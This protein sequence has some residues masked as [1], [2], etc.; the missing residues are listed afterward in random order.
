[1]PRSDPVEPADAPEPAVWADDVTISFPTVTGTVDALTGVHASFGPGAVHALVGPTGSG[2]S[3]FLRVLA[4]HERPTSGTIVVAGHVIS[5]MGGR[6]RRRVRRRDIG[7]VF[8][9][10]A[11]N[12]FTYL[13]VDEHLRVAA[14]L[15]A[16]FDP[17]EAAALLDALGL[18]ARRRHRPAQ[19]SGGEQQRLA[20]AMAAIGR[21]PVLLA[22]EPTAELDHEAGR[23]LLD[24]VGA[25]AARGT[26][27]V[28]ATHDP[29]ARERADHVVSLDHGRTGARR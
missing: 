16:T 10:P 17:D 14:R 5:R 15:R 6:A 19:L 25:L 11:A 21:P 27:V 22:D 23:H 3:S 2:K 4:G 28:F 20:F 7:F 13:D 8:Q 26:C 29:A 9:R 12:L 18:A 24:A 1:V